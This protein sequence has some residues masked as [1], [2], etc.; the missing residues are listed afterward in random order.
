LGWGEKLRFVGQEREE[1]ERDWHEDG[2]RD[3][4]EEREREE[5]GRMGRGIGMRRGRGRK[6]GGWGE[7]LA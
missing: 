3:W 1:R 5:G 2:E 7:G 6:V 4:D